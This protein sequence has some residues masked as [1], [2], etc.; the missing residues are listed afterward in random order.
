MTKYKLYNL[1]IIQNKCLDYFDFNKKKLNVR[2]YF[3]MVGVFVKEIMAPR[4]HQQKTKTRALKK[5][6]K[7][8]LKKCPKV[9]RCF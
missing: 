2:K 9:N 1:N 7:I 8:I 5:N 4:W 6:K 3:G